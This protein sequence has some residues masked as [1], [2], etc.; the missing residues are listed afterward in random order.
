MVI[1]DGISI[2][3]ATLDTSDSHTFSISRV[4]QEVVKIDPKYIRDMYYTGD[5]VETVF[6]E[7]STVTFA[8]NHN[9]FYMRLD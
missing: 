7:E 5:P 4:V 6:V 1:T 3:I 8:K 9:G 2:E